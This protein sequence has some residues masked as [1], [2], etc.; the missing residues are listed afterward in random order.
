M[1]PATVY[2]AERSALVVSIRL[3]NKEAL[4]RL[5]EAAARSGLSRHGFCLAA[6]QHHVL[7]VLSGRPSP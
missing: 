7:Q 6:I 2:E 3:P 4:Q 1:S 5:R